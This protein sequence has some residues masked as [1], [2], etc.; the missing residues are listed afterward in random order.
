VEA[1]GADD[2]VVGLGGA[3]GEGHV[4]VG[5]DGLQAGGHADLRPDGRRPLDEQPRHH[6][7]GHADGGRQVVAAGL[8]VGE[9][10]DQGAVGGAQADRVEGVPVGDHVVEHAEVREHPQGVALQR[11]AGAGGGDVGL[12]LDEVDGDAGPGQEDRGGG[13]GGPAADH[14]GVLDAHHVTAIGLT[15]DPTAPVIRSGAAVRKNS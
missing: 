10:G 4:P 6:R 13:A 11:D 1:V 5:G 12:G 9:L 8:Q 14:E 7:A 3:V 2:E 15:G